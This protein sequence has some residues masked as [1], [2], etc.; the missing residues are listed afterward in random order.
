MCAGVEATFEDFATGMT[1]RGGACS[2]CGSSHMRSFGCI[3]IFFS[4]LNIR[5]L[6]PLLVRL[7]ACAMSFA[8]ASAKP[9]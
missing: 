1:G 7:C 2:S 3:N 4:P 8:T 9:P 5:L 6:L